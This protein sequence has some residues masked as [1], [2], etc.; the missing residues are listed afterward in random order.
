MNPA[1]LLSFKLVQV[2]I[3]LLPTSYNCVL[4]ITIIDDFLHVEKKLVVFFLK[5]LE[6]VIRHHPF[7]CVIKMS[8]FYLL[9]FPFVSIQH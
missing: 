8:F 3:T 4:V 6:R 5:F 9:L 2:L 7:P 1:F